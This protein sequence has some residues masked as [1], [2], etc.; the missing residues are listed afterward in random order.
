MSR[1]IAGHNLN[2]HS[3]HMWDNKTVE[4]TSTVT[5][6]PMLQISGITT[7]H[8]IIKQR[9]LP[10]PSPLHHCSESLT[11]HYDVLCQGINSKLKNGL[12]LKNGQLTLLGP[13]F[14]GCNIAPP[15]L[16]FLGPGELPKGGPYV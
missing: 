15:I 3:L 8:K 10:P 5:P 2:L 4:L 1:S 14:W 16:L 13:T 7:P 9:S 12:K 11:N 6:T